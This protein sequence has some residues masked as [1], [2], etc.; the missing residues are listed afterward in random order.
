M[1]GL[2]LFATACSGDD[3]NSGQRG[4]GGA[5]PAPT[6]PGQAVDGFAPGVDDRVAIIGVA[7]GETLSMRVLPGEGQAVVAEIPA[8]ADELFGFGQ[9]FETPDGPLW[10]L[11]RFGDA[12]GWIQPGAAYLGAAD[13]ISVTVSGRLERTSYESMD[14]LVAEVQGQFEGSVLV[15]TSDAADGD[16]LT[17]TIDALVSGD[18]SV[19]GERVVITAAAEDDGYR[20]TAAQRIP[21]CAR[22]VDDSGTCQ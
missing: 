3:D 22:G 20:L 21:L 17:A 7:S 11:V 6:L 19:A 10:W 12:Q 13:D 9:A 2:A 1:L 4:L 16:E 14:A 15:G 8:T 5:Q 18:D